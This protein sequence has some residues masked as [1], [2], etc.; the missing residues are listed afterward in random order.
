MSEIVAKKYGRNLV[1]VIDGVKK[2]KIINTDKDKKDEESIKNKILLYNKKNNKM[3]K[4]EILYLIDSNKAKN[5]EV[6]AKAKG[7]KKSIKKETKKLES[8]QI[9]KSNIDL[10]NEIDENNLS[11]LDTKRLE[12]ILAKSKANQKATTSIVTTTPTP[13]KGEW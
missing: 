3:L 7:L 11:E 10:L 1:I 9:I 5:D 6:E 2:T 4:E 13:K 8:K 12:V